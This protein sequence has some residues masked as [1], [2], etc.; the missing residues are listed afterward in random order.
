M[1][2][3]IDVQNMHKTY[4][5]TVAV[6]DVSF[7]VQAGEIFGILGPNGAGKTTTV[8]SIAGLR[9]PDRGRIRV[10]GL[11]P[12]RDRDQLRQLVGVQLQESQLPDKLR[13]GEALELYSSFYRDPASWPDLME[14]LGLA[15]KR[16]TKFGKLS[17]GQ[18][19]R[20]SVALALVGN[21][22]IAILDELTTGLDP[23]ARRDTWAMISGIRDRGVTVVLVTHFMEEAERLCD[24]VA[25]ID[26]GRVVA[27]ESPTALASAAGAE[28]RI[29]F[30]P[31]R[32][33]DDRLLSDLPEVTSVTR[34]GGLVVVTGGNDALNAV[35][36][37]L[38]RAGIVAQQLRVDQSSLEDAFV[39]LTGHHAGPDEA[40]TADEAAAGE[41]AG[42]RN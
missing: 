26:S 23:Q 17:G 11:D 2:A 35:T 19:Q 1:T 38:V 8:E 6:D 39:A 18:R 7:T 5:G 9:A 15:G 29:R 30:R 21:P 34:Q 31:S 28:Q 20:L 36:S 14:G 3:V 16:D 27:L 40:S 24:R 33:L 4:G 13:V 12:R 10:L 25:I 42:Y 22:E 37:V 32:E 41:H